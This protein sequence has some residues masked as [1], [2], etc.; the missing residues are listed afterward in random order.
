MNGEIWGSGRE[1]RDWWEELGRERGIG[2]L[3]R[4]VSG[5]NRD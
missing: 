4:E 3:G 2:K 1:V 5:E